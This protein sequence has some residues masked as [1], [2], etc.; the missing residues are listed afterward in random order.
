[1]FLLRPCFTTIDVSA[2]DVCYSQCNEGSAGEGG[3]MVASAAFLVVLIV[4]V[5]GGTAR[6]SPVLKEPHFDVSYL[7]W[8][9]PTRL[10]PAKLL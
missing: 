9:T 4:F 6:L 3:Q 7:S 1:M 2:A 5:Q 10:P 8:C